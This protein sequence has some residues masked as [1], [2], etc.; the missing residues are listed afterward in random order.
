MTGRG[1]LVCEWIKDV[2][3]VVGQV[4]GNQG[5]IMNTTM[6]R[7]V[8]VVHRAQEGQLYRDVFSMHPC[9]TW[10]NPTVF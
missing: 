9:F 3:G 6:I 4:V 10:F 2:G 7:V 1:L 5:R 8:L